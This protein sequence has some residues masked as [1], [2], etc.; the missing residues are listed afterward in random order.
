MNGNDAVALFKDPVGRLQLL[1]LHW[2]CLVWSHCSTDDRTM[3]KAGLT[4]T[5]AGYTGTYIRI[6]YEQAESSAFI[7]KYI[8]PE[9]FYWIPWTSGHFLVRRPFVM[10]GVTTLVDSF[11]VTLEWDTVPG[12]RECMG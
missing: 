6:L 8:V 2:P 10:H 7:R 5:T 12:G 9:G 1:R 4:L 11:N 3:M